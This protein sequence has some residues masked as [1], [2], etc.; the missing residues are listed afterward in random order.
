MTFNFCSEIFGD[1]QPEVLSNRRRVI[2]AGF[3]RR[4][5]VLHVK[6]SESEIKT[7]V[8]FSKVSSN[9]F[10]GLVDELKFYIQ[11]YIHVQT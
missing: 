3:I 1:S 2:T 5:V 8:F 6:A 7:D 4:R 10:R 11:A 9:D